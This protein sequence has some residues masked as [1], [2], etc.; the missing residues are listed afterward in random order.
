MAIIG[1]EFGSII[2]GKPQAFWKFTCAIYA[3][4]KTLQ[5]YGNNWAKNLVALSLAKLKHFGNLVAQFTLLA[6]HCKTMAIIGK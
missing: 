6:K 2:F 1:K 5:N 4:G 3:L